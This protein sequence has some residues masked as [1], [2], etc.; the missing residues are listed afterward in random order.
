MMFATLVLERDPITLDML[1]GIIAGG[2]SDAGIFAV[3]ALVIYGIYSWITKPA[4]GWRPNRPPLEKTLFRAAVLMALVGYGLYGVLMLPVIMSRLSAGVEADT[5]AAKAWGS[6]ALQQNSL[7]LGA[8]GALAA[9][10]MPFLIDLTRLRWRRVW[11]LARLSFKEAIRRRVL[12]VFSS[13]LLVFLFAS[14]FMDY[15]PENQ[16]RNYVR[17]VYWAMTPLMLV[18][19][20]LIAAFSLPADIR[21]NTIHTIVTKPVERF[22]IV[23]GRFIGFTLLMT[24]VLFVMTGLSLVYVMRGVDPEA[25][26]ESERA[27]VPLYGKLRFV[28]TRDSKYQGDN[29]GREWE[30]RR[31]LVGG[32]ASPARAIWTYETLPASLAQRPGDRVT[33]EFAF[34]IFRTLKGE[35]GKGVLASFGFQTPKW[36]EKRKDEYNRARTAEMTRLLAIGDRSR[37]YAE[38][39]QSLA[40]RKPTEAEIKAFADAPDSDPQWLILSL[41]AEQFG[42]FEVPSKEIVDYHTQ[43]LEVPGGLFRSVAANPASK[44]GTPDPALR[45][46]VK[47]ESGGQYLGVAPYD[48][49]ILDAERPFEVNFFKGAIGLWL[50]LC[51]VIGIAVACSTYLSGVIAWIVT[52]F[53]YVF[54]L[55]PDYLRSIVDNTNTGGG[56]FES[57][58]RMVRRDPLVTQLDPTP[59]NRLAMGSDAI[60]RSILSLVTKI[61]PD[62]DRMDWS[63]YVAEGFNIGFTQPLLSNA[64]M[65]SG[66]LLV[67]AIV[68]YYLIRSREIAT[69]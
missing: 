37:F 44:D 19:A 59:E 50:R 22:E 21:S 9:L 12:W 43:S 47:C 67:W 31:Y 11:A 58:V 68:A 45:V 29:V 20:S 30:Y 10:A 64:I 60:F 53:I 5:Q 61:I 42:L 66:Y 39:V 56:P 49:Y 2:I 24:I 46:F 52:M 55:F 13:I 15:K 48:F 14:W 57:F 41:I 36:D 62:V 40:G 28:S 63:D 65:L 18:T 23:L 1:P 33:C 32:A 35:E 7:L 17:V 3:L 54:G 16:V 34:D 69:Y 25:A 26:Y 8:I 4:R 38:A 27:R 6:P 51:L